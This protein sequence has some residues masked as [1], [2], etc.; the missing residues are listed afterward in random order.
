MWQRTLTINGLSKAYSMTGWRLE[1]VAAP[2]ALCDSIIRVHQCT[3]SC[4]TTIAP[5]GAVAAY[6]ADQAVVDDMVAAFD[7][8]RRILIDG[9]N[10]IRGIRCPEPRGAFYASPGIQGVGRSSSE[11]AELL[12]EEAGVAVVPGDA[13][14]TEGAGHLRFS[15]AT[16]DDDL[17]E[18][19]SR[20]SRLLGRSTLGM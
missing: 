17:R 15:Y 8:R 11:L 6:S 3:V 10:S 5:V 7:R 18:G 1:F 12:L 9:L 13:F 19:I 4:A 14:G 20:I 16:S 2:R